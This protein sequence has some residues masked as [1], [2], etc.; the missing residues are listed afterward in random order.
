MG[1]RCGDCCRIN[2]EDEVCAAVTVEEASASGAK[3]VPACVE[4]EDNHEDDDEKEDDD[5]A[6]HDP[7]AEGVAARRAAVLA[8]HVGVVLCEVTHCWLQGRDRM[9][10]ERGKDLKEEERE[11]K[12]VKVSKEKKRKAEAR[13]LVR[14]PILSANADA[15]VDASFVFTKLPF[16]Y[17]N[18]PPETDYFI[19]IKH[20]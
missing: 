9:L 6:E 19:V 10:E 13:P 2:V 8:R 1:G 11:G 17:K 16:T 12:F 15:S 3:K 14:S 5:G 20:N 7:A 18:F 4:V